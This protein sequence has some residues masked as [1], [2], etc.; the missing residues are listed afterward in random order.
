MNP[1]EP[2]NP[3]PVATADKPVSGVGETP[4]GGAVN[5][6]APSSDISRVEDLVAAAQE[7]AAAQTPKGQ[8]EDQFGSGPATPPVAES[9]S[10][11]DTALSNLGTPPSAE[12]GASLNIQPPAA[13]VTPA[14]QPENTPLDP[15]QEFKDEVAQAAEKLIKAL[16]EATNKEKVVV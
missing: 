9:A 3:G 5:P 13:E 10:G 2:V 7:A 12:E 14:L 6:Q 15:Q 1:T 16:K 4:I 8:F 11:L